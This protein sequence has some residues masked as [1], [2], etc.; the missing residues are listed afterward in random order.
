MPHFSESSTLRSPRDS[1]SI[2]RSHFKHKDVGS[3]LT[4]VYQALRQIQSQMNRLR[5]RKGAQ[6][7]SFAYWA[8]GRHYD[9]TKTVSV[10]LH[11]WVQP[12]DDVVVTGV[13]D[14]DSGLNVKSKSGLYL[15][16]QNVAPVIN[17]IIAPATTLPYPLLPAGTY[18]HIPQSQL[19]SG[20]Y[21]VNNPL[22]YWLWISPST[23]CT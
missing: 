6:G 21:D 22:N 2:P 7:G 10:D 12:T 11:V 23:V 3:N 18:Y 4:S 8:E 13:T 19:P 14:P 16:L 5:V 9:K 20:D 17:Q 1:D 15:S